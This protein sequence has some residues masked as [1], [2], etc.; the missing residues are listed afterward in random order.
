MYYE[1][2]WK[3]WEYSNYAREHYKRYIDVTLK[4]DRYY[5]ILGNY[6]GRGWKVFDYTL[7]QPAILGSE[8]YKDPTYKDWF[9]NVLISATSKG[10]MYTA[11]TVGDVIRTTL[12][13]LTF[14]K[15]SF[16]GIQLDFLSDK[17]A[18]TALTSRIS[19]PA[20]SLPAR[21]GG[22]SS[23]TD[24]T[25]FLGLRGTAQVGD[26]LKIGATYVNASHWSSENSFSNSSLKGVL[27]GAQNVGNVEKLIIRLSD[28][29]PE[30]GVGGA[31]LY[32]EK[33]F[34]DGH[35]AD[36]QPRIEGGIAREG[37]LEASGDKTITLT[38]NIRSDYKGDYRLIKEIESVLVLAN[39]YKVEVT[40]NLQ[41]NAEGVP[42]FLPVTRAKGNVK[43]NS[44]QTFVHFK[45]G[46]PTGNEIYGVTVEIDDFKG[47]DL[48][49]EFNIN[50]RFRRFPNQNYIYPQ[51][52]SLA[53]DES[54]A[55]YVIVSQRNYPWFA[56][57][58]IF[59][60][61]PFYSTSF[62]IVDTKGFVDYENISN[63]QFE[64]VD[65]NDDQDRFPDW[66]RNPWNQQA[67]PGGYD[68]A[69]FPGL[70][71]NN[72]LKWDFN[73][74]D[75]LEP[76]YAEPFL[77]YNVDPPEFLF[78][79]D[80]NNNGTIDRFEN[81]RVADYPYKKGHRGYNLYTGVE[82]VPGLKVCIGHLDE[83]MIDSDRR[84]RSTYGLLTWQADYP[85]I[86]RLQLFEHIKAVKDNIPDD[87]YQ[88]MQPPLSKGGFQDAPDPLAQQN[89]TVNTTYLQFD[90]IGI[91]NFKLVNK[92]KL[93]TY[94]QH[95]SQAEGK[96]NQ[97]FF[98]V[99]N[100][101]DYRIE[102]GGKFTI[103]PKWKSMYRYMIPTNP[104]ELKIKDLTEIGFLTIEFPV[105]KSGRI[106]SGIEYTIFNNYIKPTA[107]PP[108]FVG[109]YKGVVLVTQIS[110][111]SEY[112]GYLLTSNIGFRW[113]R[114]SF[115]GKEPEV[116]SVAFIGIY[117]HVQD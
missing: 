25:N 111:T 4:G 83:Q 64:F 3:S 36:I 54:P 101:A 87:L 33:I 110:N 104:T 17:Y 13:P 93:E 65:D 106:T 100:K 15:P 58:E 99:I 102:M 63:Y 52:Q 94:F 38:Y 91:S 53:I 114:K 31:V 43:D 103:W 80:M 27:S 12:T 22:V 49:A 48:L 1:Y 92:L 55:F 56:H 18:L 78:G 88:W 60:I 68:A 95:G 81:D 10:Q 37:F 82:V 8:I 77:R 75:N 39:D 35:L 79:M 9:A 107:P 14:M 47:F 61:D 66:K 84:S 72:D 59:N 69:V 6:I 24:F 19:L 46:L 76:D 34:I 105:L 16:N 45:Y 89:T 21:L 108:G 50:R 62:F 42:V 73:Q 32:S 86:G 44:N 85:S 51:E 11:L 115:K 117:A 30:D 97:G 113:E 41:T 74:N 5:D 28:D 96:R 70:D 90:Y 109:N 112:W 71:E 57:G 67:K 116:N 2:G 7:T 26:F 40:S 20:V 29:S 23:L 98:G